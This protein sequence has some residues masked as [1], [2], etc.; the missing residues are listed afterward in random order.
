[1]RTIVT[2]LA[3]ACAI[4]TTACDITPTPTQTTTTTPTTPGKQ[5]SMPDLVGK[6]L[7]DAQDQIQKLTGDKLFYT[8]SHDLSGQGRH[9][10][11]DDNWKVCTQ[12]VAPGAA[13]TPASKIDFGVVKLE[14][15]C[16]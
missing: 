2:I 4:S 8:G 9:Q 10:V 7:Q 6:G 16:P 15:S 12:N 5:W 11:V 14:E 13:L 3:V 1:V